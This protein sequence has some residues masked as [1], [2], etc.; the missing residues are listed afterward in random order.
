M[1]LAQMFEQAG[2]SAV[3]VLDA[4]DARDRLPSIQPV[5]DTLVLD[6][7]LGDMTGLDLLR[8]WKTDLPENINVIFVSGDELE[9]DSKEEC[10]KLGAHTFWLKPLKMQSLQRWVDEQEAA[11]SMGESTTRAPGQDA[12]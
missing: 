7:E 12:A 1:V 2:C 6:W 10:R 8:Q 9:P 5:V 11:G 3:H 4:K